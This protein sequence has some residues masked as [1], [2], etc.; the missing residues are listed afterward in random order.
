[1][2]KSHRLTVGVMA[3]SFKEAERRLALHPDHLA[4]LPDEV[5]SALYLETGYAAAFGAHDGQLRELVAGVLD[6]DELVARCDVIVQ[7]KPVLSEVSDLRDGQVLWGWPH[8]VQDAALTQLAID[9][10]LTLIAFEAMNHW[11]REGAFKLHVFH[12]NNEMA[13]YCSVLHATSLAGVTGTYG[14]RMRAAVI[15]FGA[16]ARGAV[17]ALTSIGVHDVDVLTHRDIAAVAAPIHSAT[18]VNFGADDTR[19]SVRHVTT[20]EGEVPVA[21]FLAEHDI[22][23]NCVLQ[24]PD[25]PLMFLM[26]DDLPRLAPGTIVIDVS[27]DDGMGFEWATPTTFEK[28]TFE[29]GE[30]VLYYAV[31]HSPSYLFNSATW[32]NSD[33]LMPFLE[34]VM[35]GPE[36]WQAEPTIRRAIEI[37]D[38]VIVN[39]AILSFQGRS[40]DY[41]HPRA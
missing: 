35:A 9:K 17:T 19:T 33:A 38:G 3:T 1:M 28:P 34:T 8:C 14:R 21:Q 5:R 24:D 23:V 6:R 25:S 13:G 37:R 15:G 4:R 39:P 30:N 31:D 11:S 27:C 16:T 41:P 7:P 32:E 22:I 29:V 2:T 10:K 18:I 26:N 20:D 40:A 12:K 36:A